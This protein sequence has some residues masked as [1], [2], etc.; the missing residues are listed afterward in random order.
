MRGIN[1]NNGE[2]AR[3]TFLI[4]DRHS[5]SSFFRGTQLD[6]AILITWNVQ[7]GRPRALKSQ[8]YLA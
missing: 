7:P 8:D 5:R 4:C 3:Y 2:R 6:A 1:K